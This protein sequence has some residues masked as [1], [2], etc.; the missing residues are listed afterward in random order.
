MAT[1]SDGNGAAGHN[2]VEVIYS[3]GDFSVHASASDIN[4]RRAIVGAYTWTGWTFALGLQDSNSATDTDWTASVGGDIGPA[5]VNLTYADNG[6]SG[7]HWVLA[8]RFD[9]GAATNI[10]AY[11]ADSSNPAN[12]DDDSYGIDFNHD[13]G[14]GTSVRGGVAKEF[15]GDTVADLGV[16]FD[17]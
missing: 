10:E 17:F 1:P 11:F 7:E 8:G 16:R 2:G 12:V 4:D 9:V 14:G 13:L 3:F 15:D 6:V 5:F